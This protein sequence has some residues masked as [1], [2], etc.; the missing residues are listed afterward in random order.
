M[1]GMD[2]DRERDKGARGHVRQ[3]ELRGPSHYDCAPSFMPPGLDHNL[4]APGQTKGPGKPG[5]TASTIEPNEKR[6]RRHSETENFHVTWGAAR[7]P[8]RIFE[9]LKHQ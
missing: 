1:G 6:H 7:H 3:Q 8:P 5:R 2:V 4:K 9:C